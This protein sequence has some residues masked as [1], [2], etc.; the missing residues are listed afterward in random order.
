MTDLN[1]ILRRLVQKTTDGTLTWATTVREDQF[2]SSVDGIRILV[3]ASGIAHTLE[4]A[5]ETGQRIETLDYSSTTPEQ[6]QLLQQ[7]FT[8]ARRSA[9][10]YDE[11]LAKLAKALET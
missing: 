1:Q 7:L 4:I 2:R 10:K 5:D 3:R 11:T 9:L 6:D 8:Q